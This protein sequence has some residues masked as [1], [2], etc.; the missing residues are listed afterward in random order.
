MPERMGHEGAARPR[1]VVVGGGFGGLEVVRALGRAPVDITLIDRQNHHCFQPLLYQ[2]ATAALSPADIAWPIRGIVGSRPNV[3]V[4]MAEVDAVDTAGRC[5][6]TTAAD[7]PYDV[8]VLA[9]GATHSYFGHDEW[10]E[11]A[12]GL[13]RVEDATE[14]RRRVLIAFERAELVSDPAERARL[15]TFVLVGGGPTGVE[16]AG[17]IAELA[18]HALPLDFHHI[19]PR[20]ARIVLV[21][22]GP[23]ILAAFPEH[24]SAYAKRALEKMGVEVRTGVPVTACDESGVTLAEERLPAATIIWAAGVVASPAARWLGVESDRAGR[25][26]VEA[27][28][29]VPGHPEIFAIGDTATRKQDGKPIPG[30]APAA[31][32]MGRYVGRRIAARAAGEPETG[33]FVYRHQGDLATIGRKAAVVKLGRLELRGFLG[34]VFWSVVH[35]YFLIGTRNRLSVALSW[36]WNYLTFQR[37]ARLITETGP[38]VLRRRQKEG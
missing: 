20:R 8:L 18:R 7:I 34:W 25:V 13:K 33:P 19:D 36:G 29:S 5:V 1:V 26:P 11:A 9:T 38:P 28:L 15:M 37:G 4:L 16:M 3:T 21:E 22:A 14:I 23:R 12:P 6:R 24:L 30:I 17:A 35:V 31:K 27:D 32:Q 10:S 2:V